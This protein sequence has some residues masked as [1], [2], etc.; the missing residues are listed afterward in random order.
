MTFVGA[1]ARFV[2]GPGGSQRR[3]GSVSKPSGNGRREGLSKEC[4]AGR[5][6]FHPQAKACAATLATTFTKDLAMFIR[7]LSA[8]AAVAL[9][10]AT[11]AVS[12]SASAQTGES[13]AVR[14]GDLDL[15]TST[16]A[17]R[18]ER[19]VH[20]AARAVCGDLSA[21]VRLN[22]IVAACQADAAAGAKAGMDVALA[23]K[24]GGSRTVA[25]NAN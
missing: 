6:L 1:D 9:T 25:L 18:F 19:R 24:P 8:L 11:L 15:A 10:G 3:F 20:K 7:T 22:S 16:G 12:T 14:Y 21:D 13:V 5:V 4:D 2:A 17:E 23:G